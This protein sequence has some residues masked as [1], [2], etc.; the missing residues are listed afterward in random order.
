MV[1]RGEREGEL[2][3]A[4]SRLIKP[5]ESQLLVHRPYLANRNNNNNSISNGSSTT[6]TKLPFLSLFLSLFPQTL[7][8]LSLT[9]FNFESNACSCAI[10]FQLLDVAF[11]QNVV[12]GGRIFRQK[13]KSSP[14]LARTQA[15]SCDSFRSQQQQQWQQQQQQQHEQAVVLR[16]TIFSQK[17]GN[18][19]NFEV[20]EKNRLQIA[21]ILVNSSLGFASIE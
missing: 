21:A 3:W 8:V 15:T 14:F 11:L 5:L 10:G 18:E 16:N 19:T 4:S 2:F 7:V 1:R 9:C 13:T 17:R 20:M 12:H 6:T